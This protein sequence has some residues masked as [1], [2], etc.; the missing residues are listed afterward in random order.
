MA[1]YDAAIKIGDVQGGAYNEALTAK[2]R[3]IKE[4]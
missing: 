4:P 1:V 2:A 3:L